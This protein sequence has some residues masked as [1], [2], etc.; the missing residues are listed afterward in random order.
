MVV[1]ESRLETPRLE[2]ATSFFATVYLPVPGHPV[3]ENTYDTA[4]A[5]TVRRHLL[6]A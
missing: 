2:L 6:L 4:I 1:D 3:S 5:A